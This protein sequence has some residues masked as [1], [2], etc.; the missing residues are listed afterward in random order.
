MAAEPAPHPHAPEHATL[1]PAQRWATFASGLLLILGLL[2]MLR[3]GVGDWSV[4]HA[5]HFFEWPAHF[6]TG[7]AQFVI[8]VVGVACLGSEHVTRAY[9]TVSGLFLTA[10]AIAGAILNANPNDVFTRNP[11]LVGLHLIL[12]LVSLILAGLSARAAHRVAL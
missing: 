2:A 11:W 10:W 9:L 4:R 1:S 8:G 5:R 7:V 12:G 3:S 6:L